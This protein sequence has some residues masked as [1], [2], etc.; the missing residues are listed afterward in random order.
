MGLGQ[1][2]AA[3][4]KFKGMTQ[5]KLAEKCNVSRQAVAK[6]ETGESELSIEK[7]VALSRVFNISIDMVSRICALGEEARIGE[8]I[9]H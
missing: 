7:L 5:E 8:T 2:I 4:R 6:W 3:L 9:V 1:N